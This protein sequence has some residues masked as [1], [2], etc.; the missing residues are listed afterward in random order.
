MTR[1]YKIH[2]PREYYVANVLQISNTNIYSTNNRVR[3]FTF[4]PHL[5]K[6]SHLC[7]AFEPTA[8]LPAAAPYTHLVSTSTSAPPSRRS[9]FSISI[10]SRTFRGRTFS[11]RLFTLLY[12]SQRV[13]GGGNKQQTSPVQCV[14]FSSKYFWVNTNLC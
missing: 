3:F 7:A 9:A 2:G 1:I 8:K 12:T 14:V 13:L 5:L 4:A 6:Q 10:A 11:R